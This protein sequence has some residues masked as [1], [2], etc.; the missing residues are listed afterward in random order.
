ML[1]F[2]LP[3]FVLLCLFHLLTQYHR[4]GV[5]TGSYKRPYR[6]V[7]SLMS[8]QRRCSYQRSR[9]ASRHKV[10]RAHLIEKHSKE[11]LKQQQWYSHNN[12]TMEPGAFQERG[13]EF[14]GDDKPSQHDRDHLYDGYPDNDRDKKVR[15]MRGPSGRCGQ[16]RALRG[17]MYTWKVD[18]LQSS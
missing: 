13:R 12:A 9:P 15:T 2:P 6:P 8:S 3:T 14:Q 7:R 5:T 17:S 10:T 18:L 4:T 11:S 1:D 16:T